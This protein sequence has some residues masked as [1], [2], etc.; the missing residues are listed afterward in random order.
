MENAAY[1]IRL[2]QIEQSK[3]LYLVLNFLQTLR[4]WHRIWHNKSN[5]LIPDN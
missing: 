4:A 2:R 1:K 5:I 3:Y